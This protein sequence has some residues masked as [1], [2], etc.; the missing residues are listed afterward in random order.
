MS[1]VNTIIS[2]SLVWL[3]VMR[4]I[5]PLREEF[6]SARPLPG[7][8]PR[9]KDEA[10]LAARHQTYLLTR[11]GNTAPWPGDTGDWST[12]CVVAFNPNPER[13]ARHP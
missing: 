9:L 7:N 3:S 10:I 1:T 5:I 13:G 2:S 8:F 11:E 12:I 4:R 6:L